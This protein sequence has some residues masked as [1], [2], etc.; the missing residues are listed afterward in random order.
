MN[1]QI[2]IV[3]IYIKLYQFSKNEDI[4][5]KFF[6]RDYFL[7][8]LKEDKLKNLIHFIENLKTEDYIDIMDK[9]K[10]KYIIKEEDFSLLIKKFQ[11]NY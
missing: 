9:L 3:E 5:A 8:N 11:L 10:E 4:D 6:I 2:L 1:Q 7:K